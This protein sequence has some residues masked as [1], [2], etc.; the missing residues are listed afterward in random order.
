MG[1]FHQTEPTEEE[2]K[3]LIYFKIGDI[4]GK[5]GNQTLN[6]FGAYQVD[7]QSLWENTFPDKQK[8]RRGL[9]KPLDSTFFRR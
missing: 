3:N 9:H 4:T 1:I 2:V 5:Y 8:E 6:G 7:L